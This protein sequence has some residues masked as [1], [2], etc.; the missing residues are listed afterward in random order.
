MWPFIISH[1]LEVVAIP[2]TSM[3][4]V[5]FQFLSSTNSINMCIA[6]MFPTDHGGVVIHN[7]YMAI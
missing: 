7:H 1:I 3:P 4:V 5:L 2:A 6:R